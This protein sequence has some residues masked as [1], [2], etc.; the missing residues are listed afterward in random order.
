MINKN[1]RIGLTIHSMDPRKRKLP[2]LKQ[3][4]DE[5]QNDG[6]GHCCKCWLQSDLISINSWF[7]EARRQIRS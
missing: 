1:D 6:T 4:L 3:F 2:A 5:F 7:F